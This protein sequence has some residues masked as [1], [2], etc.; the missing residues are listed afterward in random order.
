MD[1]D[2]WKARA[3]KAEALAEERT[4]FAMQAYTEIQELKAEVE[5]LRSLALLVSQCA[6]GSPAMDNAM[7]A[8][9][10]QW[11]AQQEVGDE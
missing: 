3:E 4:K 5:R 7:E 1:K 2:Y 9:R 10:K 8:C 11:K 6:N